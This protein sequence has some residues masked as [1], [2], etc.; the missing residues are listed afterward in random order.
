MEVP[1]LTKLALDIINLS[2]PHVGSAGQYNWRMANER[3]R[4]SRGHGDTETVTRPK[5]R[6]RPP[7]QF[8]VILHNDDFTTMEFVVWVL[9]DVFD[10]TAAEATELMLAVHQDGAAT[11]GAYS[12]E[13]AETKRDETLAQAEAQGMPLLV[14]IE[15]AAQ[16]G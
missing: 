8:A 10:K 2:L 6:N 11:V 16:D 14:T 1:P 15:P 9:V 5:T 4:P 13:V 3:E 7:R 12:R